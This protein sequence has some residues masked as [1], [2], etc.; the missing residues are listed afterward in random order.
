M[1]YIVALVLGFLLISCGGGGGSSSN[2][3][4]IKVLDGYIVGA[5]V[6][7]SDNT[8]VRFIDDNESEYFNQYRFY[9][10]PKGD[11]H[12]KGGY[13]LQSGLE[14]K[15]YL[16]VPADT[17]IITPVVMFLNKHPS[18]LKSI[19]KALKASEGRLRGDYIKKNN[20]RVARF[21]Q[22][23]YALQIH[24]LSDRFAD[25]LSDVEN[26]S[27]IIVSALRAIEG[28]SNEQKIKSFIL[29][30]KDYKDAKTL[31]SDIYSQKRIMQSEVIVNDTNDGNSNDDGA[32]YLRGLDVKSVELDGN[33]ALHVKFSEPIENLN[34]E[35]KSAIT[36]SKVIHSRVYI[37]ENETVNVSGKSMSVTLRNAIKTE[38][39]SNTYKI[40]VKGI[41]SSQNLPLQNKTVIL[42]QAPVS[43]VLEDVM[44]VDG[45]HLKAKFNLPIDSGSA[46][47]NDFLIKSKKSGFTPIDVSV[48]GE[49]GE[50]LNITLGNTMTKNLGYDFTIKSDNLSSTQGLKLANDVKKEFIAKKSDVI[51]LNEGFNLVNASVNEEQ[52]EIT[53]NFSKVVMSNP[54]SDMVRISLEKRSKPIDINI[55]QSAQDSALVDV[56]IQKTEDKMLS[57]EQNA[58]YLLSVEKQSI[59]SKDGK[60]TLGTSYHKTLEVKNYPKVVN[61]SINSSSINITFNMPMEDINATDVSLEDGNITSLE[62]VDA[63]VSGGDSSFSISRKDGK[64][65][66]G[67]IV[68][69]KLKDNIYTKDKK[70]VLE[71]PYM[72]DFNLSR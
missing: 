30:L 52:T 59:F 64:D 29:S 49:N 31:E 48:D 55:T 1:K 58:T 6:K 65:F 24:A 12:V 2:Y 63:A 37:D 62:K 70:S 4:Y 28:T 38:E 21:A 7:D 56:K 22:I 57:F 8:P 60:R 15:L 9:D 35:K 54:T 32:I 36:L 67:E 69:V 40:H 13:F 16:K 23:L 26:E 18:T 19:S 61:S 72:R 50:I 5:N 39:K 11:I 68:R 44:Y 41:R 10:K 42:S 3:T 20:I 25:F 17:R 53:L 43:L 51:N 27:D 66:N 14:N 46:H 33:L 47:Q 45:K 71:T 34:D